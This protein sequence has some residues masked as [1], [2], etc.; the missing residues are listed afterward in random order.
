MTEGF[1]AKKKIEDICRELVLPII[2]ANRFELVD[3][4]FVKEGGH[5]YLRVYMDKD[6]GITI[7]DCVKVSEELSKKLDEADPI[8]E[9]YSLEVS[10][11]GVERPLKTEKDFM[12]SEGEEVEV[13]LFE[14]VGG[15]KIFKGN[16]VGV[17]D[18]EVIISESDKNIMKFNKNKVVY[19]KRVLKF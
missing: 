6:G 12:R 10:S 14:P 17:E 15:K 7:D 16:L 4:E 1:M 3:I 2:D 19:V 13:K 9:S 8:S 18:N 5:S 11:K